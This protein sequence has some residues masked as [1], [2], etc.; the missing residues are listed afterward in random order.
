MFEEQ[1]RRASVYIDLGKDSRKIEVYVET[2][3]RQRGGHGEDFM[4]GR[5]NFTARD[6]DDDMLG[7]GLGASLMLDF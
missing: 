7:A 4:A 3:D 1:R 6:P 2:I 5:E